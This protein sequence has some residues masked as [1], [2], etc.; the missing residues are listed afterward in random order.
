M[1]DAGGKL[2]LSFVPTK[3]YALVNAIEVN[4]ESE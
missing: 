2:I 3:N 4:D 1:A